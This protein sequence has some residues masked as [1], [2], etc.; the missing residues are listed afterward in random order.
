MILKDSGLGLHKSK[1]K[2]SS[3]IKLPK[4]SW[5]K[6]ASSRPLKARRKTPARLLC[7]YFI[8]CNSNQLIRK[9]FFWSYL[10]GTYINHWLSYFYQNFEKSNDRQVIKSKQK[11]FTLARVG[12]SAGLLSCDG[13][14]RYWC[15]VVLVLLNHRMTIKMK[16]TFFASSSKWN[17]NEK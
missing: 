10:I 17:E 4:N 5:S 6:Y 1:D 8:L 3:S 11:A 2:N 9:V 13:N 15:I 16:Y 14:I 7:V 12:W